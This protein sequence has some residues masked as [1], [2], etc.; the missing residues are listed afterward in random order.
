V[1]RDKLLRGQAFERGMNGTG[2]DV[3]VEPRRD[4]I[5]DRPP[6][7]ILAKPDDS[8]STACSN[9]PSVSAISTTL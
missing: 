7:R 3:A 4:V 1:R 6:T 9:A 8:G 5:Q 2:R